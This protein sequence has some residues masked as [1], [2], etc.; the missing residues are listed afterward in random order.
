MTCPK[1]NGAMGERSSGRVRVRQCG[2]CQGVFL[3][4]ADLG[5]LVEAENDWHANRST[6]TA[7]LPRITA[8]MTSPPPAAKARSYV[9]SLFTGR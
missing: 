7:Q 6:D 3:D 1:C 4:R 8:E 9:D 2:S 5:S